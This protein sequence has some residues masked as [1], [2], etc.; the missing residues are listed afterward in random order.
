MHTI[1]QQWGKVKIINV[2]TE[3]FILL[4]IRNTSQQHK[5]ILPESKGRENGFPSI[6]T[7]EASI[8]S[9]VVSSKIDEWPNL[10]QRLREG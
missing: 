4:W 9:I 1:T 7:W 3:F 10:L 5:Y 2:K 6:Q 8:I